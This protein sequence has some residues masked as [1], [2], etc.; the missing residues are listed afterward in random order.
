MTGILEQIGRVAASL[1]DRPAQRFQRDGQWVGRSYAEVYAAATEIGRGLTELGVRP[2]DRVAIFA[3]TS[4]EWTLCHLGI[5]AAGGVLVSIYP[6]NSPEEVEWVLSDSGASVVVCGDV[7][8]VGKVEK[9]RGVLPELRHVVVVDG[10]GLTLA[11]LRERGAASAAELPTGRDEAAPATFIYTS[12]TTGRPKGCVLTHRNNEAVAAE[13]IDT[14]I[15]GADDAAYLFLPLAHIFAQLVQNGGLCV[16]AEIVYAGGDPTR[17]VSELMATAPT[18][19]PSVPRVF[20]K[21]Y[22]TVTA[23]L[24]DSPEDQE[25]FDLSVQAGVTARLH[26]QRGEPVP[27]A[28]QAAVD[29]AD[30]AIFAGVRALFGGRIR[31]AISG[32][33][34]IGADVLRFFYACGVPVYEGFGM[35]ETAGLISVNLPNAMRIGTV[36]RAVGRAEVRIADDG[37][38]ELSGP[39]IFGEYWGNPEATRETFTEDGWMSTGDLGSVDEE[40]FLSIT[41]RKKDIII[42]AGG[43]NLA[44]ANLENDLKKS[45]WVSQVVMY[46]DRRPYPVALVTLDAEQILPWAEA[47]GLPSDLAELAAD[48]RVRALVAADL[49]RANA[50][51]AQVEQIK[52][53]A[54]LD[55]DF[56]Q[57]TGELTPTLK[58]KRQVVHERFGEF[59]DRLYD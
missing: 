28:L 14:G 9:V 48:D 30:A 40:G 53:F 26:Q 12:G 36:G 58:L 8:Q 49:D 59:F 23:Q 18:M 47:N 32:A 29:Q 31:M 15:L 5:W 6:T 3:P 1:G 33:A 7:G 51:Y 52:R 57:E 37:E 45:R 24:G 42:T 39:M 55:H 21:I 50:G 44:P 10:P 46:G 17:L 4:P 13:V 34:P 54:I 35:T 38:I 25:R 20:E 22:A 43:K 56:S 19:L 27:A 11:E 2:G 16:G 41:G